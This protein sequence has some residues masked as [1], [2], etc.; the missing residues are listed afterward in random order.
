MHGIVIFR[1]DDYY[2]STNAMWA[3]DLAL[4]LW[5]KLKKN[6][7]VR[8]NMTQIA[9]VQALAAVLLAYMYLYI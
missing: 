9:N 5:A 4:S 2:Q 8:Q 7:K 6:N 1:C 3:H